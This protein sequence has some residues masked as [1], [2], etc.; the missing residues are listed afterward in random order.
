MQPLLTSRRAT[1]DTGR[2]M[3]ADAEP[4][5]D[6]PGLSRLREAVASRVPDLPGGSSLRDDGLAGL[7]SAVASVPDG[8]ASGLL[9][10]VNPIYGLYAC[11]AG[12][13][14]KSGG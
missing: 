2:R 5:V 13:D 4:E 11:M 1:R 7:N 9:A 12:P 8:L 6:Q 10:G 3:N 14:R